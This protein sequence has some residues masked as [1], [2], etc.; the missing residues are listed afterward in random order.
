MIRISIVEDNA[1]A[2]EKLESYIETYSRRHAEIF[3]IRL[4]GD[5]LDFLDS[6]QSVYD[7]V[8]MDIDL[9]YINGL[10]AA[11]RLR[12]MDS[13]VILIFVTNMAQFAVKGYEVNA[14]EYIVKPVSYPDF[15]LKLQRAVNG[16]RKEKE[17]LVITKQGGMV[18]LLLRDILYVEVIGHKLYYHTGTDIIETVGKLSDLEEKLYSKGFLR[19][20]KGYIVNHR[21]V[22]SVEGYKLELDNEEILPISRAK[23]TQ[24]MNELTENFGNGLTI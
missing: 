4:F 19:I 11:H 10:E 21:H 24:F 14:L 23:K 9:P 13:T 1:S 6:Y 5:A 18:R 8:F 2:A 17:S 20:G 12:K 7:I 15:E 16:C 22:M 3:H